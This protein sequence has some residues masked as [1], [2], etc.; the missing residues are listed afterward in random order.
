VRKDEDR[1]LC[2]TFPLVAEVGRERG[3]CR[4]LIRSAVG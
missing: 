3:G 2:M 4:V 1:D